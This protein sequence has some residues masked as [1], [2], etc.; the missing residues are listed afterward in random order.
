MR[1]LRRVRATPGCRYDTMRRIPDSRRLEDREAGTEPRG[2][3]ECVRERAGAACAYEASE[4]KE[5]REG[6][7]NGRRY[8]HSSLLSRSAA[9][10]PFPRR[11]TVEGR[12]A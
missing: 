9:C 5:A 6:E 11:P 4:A 8:S 12:V 1:I 7:P 10:P 2:E 3:I